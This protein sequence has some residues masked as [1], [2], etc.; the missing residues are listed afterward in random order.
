MG[1]SA[2]AKKI[3][4]G[5]SSPMFPRFASK[6]WWNNSSS[7]KLYPDE[8]IHPSPVD[9]NMPDSHFLIN[10]PELCFKVAL[11]FLVE[12]H[13]VFCLES[14]KAT[15]CLSCLKNWIMSRRKRRLWQNSYLSERRRKLC[16]FLFLI[17]M[18]VHFGDGRKVNEGSPQR[19][20]YTLHLLYFDSLSLNTQMS[21][22]RKRLYATLLT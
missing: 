19:W 8:A 9:G 17:F 4:L 20:K 3:T 1:I 5:Q 18:R 6:T 10:V 12:T 16:L 22:Q 7:N 13:L 11:H 21:R 14:F 15:P 2:V